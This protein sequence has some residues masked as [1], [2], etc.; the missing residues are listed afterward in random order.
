MAAAIRCHEP[1]LVVIDTCF[2]ASSELLTALGDLDAVNV[3]ASLLLP[4]SGFVYGPA[5]VA[6]ADPMVRA[7]AVQTQLAS[8]H[9]YAHQ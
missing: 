6:A 2:S 9:Q 8:A 3:A 5:F 1:E 7:A 4:S